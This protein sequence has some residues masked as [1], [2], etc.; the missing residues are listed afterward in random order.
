MWDVSI[1]CL[2][3]ERICATSAGVCGRGVGV[4]AFNSSTALS[5]VIKLT[6]SNEEAVPNSVPRASVW[7]MVSELG[8]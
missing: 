4:L 7:S 6:S 8:R 5:F 3:W 1:E 2:S